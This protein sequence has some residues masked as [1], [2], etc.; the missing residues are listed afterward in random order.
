M[1]AKGPLAWQNWHEWKEG[2]EHSL[3]EYPLFTDAHVVSQVNER[4]GPYLI[5]N[6]EPMRA[7]LKAAALYV[8]LDSHLLDQMPDLSV[9][10]TENWHGGW[11]V[12]EVAALLSLATGIRLK[13]GRMS[14]RFDQGDARGRPVSCYPVQDSALSLPKRAGKPI[15]PRLAKESIKLDVSLLKLL[16][17]LSAEDATAVIRAARLYQ[18]GVWISETEPHLS[19]LML[20]GALEVA[21]VH[22][23]VNGEVDVVESFRLLA[24]SLSESI[25]SEGGDALLRMIADWA[26]EYTRSLRRFINFTLQYLPDPPEERPSSWI[27]QVSWDTSQMKKALNKVYSHR[28]RALHSGIRF[29]YFMCI[30]HHFRDFIAE[31]SPGGGTRSATW[32]ADDVPMNLH[33]FEYIAR[34]TLLNWCKSK[35]GGD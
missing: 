13:A 17:Q 15:L 29:P 23:S 2:V 11:I 1:G 7:R 16:P 26:A 31:R 30:T 10:N 12:D 35:Q 34:H 5:F 9:T 27:H 18:D 21:A 6:A 33:T 8:R 14:R 20:V 4:V 32:V 25:V 3:S 22:E 19:W 24:P 28:S